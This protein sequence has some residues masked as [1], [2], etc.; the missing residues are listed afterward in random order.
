MKTEPLTAEQLE[1]IRFC[2]EECGGHYDDWAD[3]EILADCRRL[4]VEKQRAKERASEEEARIDALLT[5]LL[6]K[7]YAAAKRCA[8]QNG[9]DL[10]KRPHYQLLGRDVIRFLVAGGAIEY[11]KSI[12][13]VIRLA[14]ATHRRKNG[15]VVERAAC[16]NMSACNEVVLP[17]GASWTRD[18]LADAQRDADWG[19]RLERQSICVGDDMRLASIDV[20]FSLIKTNIDVEWPKYRNDQIISVGHDFRDKTWLAIGRADCVRHRLECAGYKIIK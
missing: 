10:P 9:I 18:S 1:E 19:L 14:V 4:E 2:R 17:D 20:G 16:G 15:F 12:A 13:S 5:D 7:A 6:P 8:E 11:R 3:E